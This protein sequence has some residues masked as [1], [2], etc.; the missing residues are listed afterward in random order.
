MNSVANN[1]ILLIGYGNPIRGDDGLGPAIADF[2]EKK[3]IAGLTIDSDYQLT[4]EDS[5]QVAEND[6]VIFA[7][8]SLDCS[9]PF[10][11]K[12]VLAKEGSNISTHS[13]EPCD[14]M[15]LAEKLFSAKTKGYVLGIRGYDF[16]QF[17][18]DL[19]EKAKS[20]LQ[21]AADFIEKII[22][23]KNFAEAI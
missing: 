2:F 12:P 21:K 4:V 3:K 15:F 23:T 9:E 8:A 19:T 10:S 13:V 11:F 18:E 17:K 1:K 6:I 20:N 16:Q 22:L 14:V 5:S 7:D